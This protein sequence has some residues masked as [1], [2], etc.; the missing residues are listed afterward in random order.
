MRPSRTN[1]GKVY[2][3]VFL[4]ML[5]AVILAIASSFAL[6]AVTGIGPA[7]AHAADQSPDQSS[8][9]SPDQSPAVDSIPAPSK[10]ILNA[11][12]KKITTQK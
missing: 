4:F 5:G 8:D 10:S 2:D 11:D 7:A 1:T 9:Q 3:P 6:R 12:L